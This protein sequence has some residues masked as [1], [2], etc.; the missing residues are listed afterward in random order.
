MWQAVAYCGLS[1]VPASLAGRFNFDPVLI[2][3]LVLIVAGH[4]YALRRASRSWL[5]PACGWGVAAAALLSPLCALSVALFSA[6]IAQHML[7]LLVAAPL[8]AL[9]MPGQSGRGLWP[10]AVTFLGTLWL[11]H[12]PAPY[13]ATFHSTALYWLMHLTLFGSSIWLWRELIWHRAD[14]G[15]N[16]LVAGTASSMQMS[17]LGALLT[18]GSH[19]WYSVHYLTTAAWGLTPLADQ[20]L[21]GAL[22]WV[23][24][25]GLFFWVA[26]RSMHRSWAAVE[27]RQPA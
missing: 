10:S 18:L 16:V 17:L 22:M 1:P 23:P 6:R 20:Q 7:L 11:W 8:I 19:G 27:R 15:A 12:M 3:A 4:I 2:A 24:G 9:G 5:A 25:C 13:D 14:D 26:L 21:G